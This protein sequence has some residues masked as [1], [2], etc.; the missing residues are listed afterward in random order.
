[1]KTVFSWV[2]FWPICLYD[3]VEKEAEHPNNFEPVI[4]AYATVNLMWFMFL[5]TIL[6]YWLRIL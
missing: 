5:G 3:I 4:V 2:F 6:I 1:M